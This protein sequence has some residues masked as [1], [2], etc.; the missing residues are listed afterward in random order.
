MI[1]TVN[2]ADLV[3]NELRHQSGMAVR[4]QQLEQAGEFEGDPLPDPVLLD[5]LRKTFSRR[6]AH[7]D[8]RGLYTKTSV[9]ELKLA[10]LEEEGESAYEIF[11]ENNPAPVIPFF[12][13]EGIAETAE[14]DTCEADSEE[15]HG[16]PQTKSAFTGTEYGTA[17]HRLLELF[18]Y[19]RFRNPAQVD[20]AAFDLWRRELA[21]GGR[22]PASYADELP[23]G[24]ILSFLHS[25]LAGRMADAD[26]RGALFREQ[27]FV[28]G[29]EANRLNPEFPK[30]E[31][32][33]VQGIID[34]YFI[35]NGELI[36][37]DYKTDRVFEPQELRDRYQIQLD[38]Y[39]QAL[40]RIT[41]MKVREKLIYSISLRRVI[42]L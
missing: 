23:A 40:S 10:S 21:D 29:I 16:S 22:I 34:A 20:Q 30:N 26:S 25:E 12:A 42:P 7:E 2:C 4:K 11:P 33:L 19:G 38:L 35:E 24:G 3:W 31:T 36:L 5:Q 1:R 41:G 8:L 13:M 28:L 14:S 18:D 15:G 39:E 6:Y 37:V 9:S 17:V 27:P 32:V